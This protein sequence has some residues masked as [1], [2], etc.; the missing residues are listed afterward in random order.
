[1]NAL[2]KRYPE[3]ARRI[4]YLPLAALP[5]PVRVAGALVED[6][7]VD[8]LT[9]K[10][11]DV[12]GDPYGGNKVR[13]LAFL[14]A[15]AQARG[16]ETTVTFGAAGSNHA[17]ATA[18]YARAAGLRPVSML[19][20]QK[21]TEKVRKNLLRGYAAGATLK[22][23]ESRRAVS[24]DTVAQVVAA[25]AQGQPRPYIIPA[26]GSSPVGTL[27]FVDAGLELAAQV[28]AGILPAPQVLYVASG[29]MGTCVGL[30]IGLQLAGLKTR[31]VAVR[32]TAPPFTSLARA[33]RLYR[34]TVGLLH[35]YLPALGPL[36][37][38]EDRFLLRDEFLGPHYGFLTEAGE[39]A[40]AHARN[41]LGV[42]LEGVYT[43]KAL[44]CLL[45]DARA[46]QL[47]GQS[48][49]FWN[50]YNSRPQADAVAGVD[51]RQLPEPFHRYFTEV[52]A[53][54]GGR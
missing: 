22:H 1:V 50:T 52:A 18:I 7:A 9:L 15:D 21:N 28:Q 13:K 37:F 10:C 54:D 23:F 41:R 43:G 49:L 3:L 17:L 35:R 32:V 39:A 53:P 34:R 51:Y 45:A 29:T 27:G 30:L 12:T 48:V 40:V 20:P 16:A 42:A 25:A 19:V 6:G 26:G 47:A 24:R 46:G 4:P 11:D 5:T 8:S 2:F 31:V 44:A 38:P 14:I 36:R 33:H